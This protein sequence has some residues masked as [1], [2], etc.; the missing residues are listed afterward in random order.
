[1]RVSFFIAASRA[2]RP[3]RK[4][5]PGSFLAG[6]PLRGKAHAAA[7]NSLTIPFLKERIKQWIY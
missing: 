5:R 4:G 1:M 2:G 7:E 6:L 3:A